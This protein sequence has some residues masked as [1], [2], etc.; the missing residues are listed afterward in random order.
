M[1]DCN[2]D[3]AV[4]FTR[5]SGSS[6]AFHMVPVGKLRRE[7]TQTAT[8]HS[9]SDAVKADDFS[10]KFILWGLWALDHTQQL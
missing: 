10:I 8:F 1:P 3:L 2:L 6:P 7:R 5:V 4:V 9:S